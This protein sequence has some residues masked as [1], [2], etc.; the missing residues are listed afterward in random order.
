[1]FEESVQNF[2]ALKIAIERD[3]PSQNAEQALEILNRAFVQ[4]I[5]EWY[6][7]APNEQGEQSVLFL[8]AQA[9]FHFLGNLYIGSIY[10][11]DEDLN[12]SHDATTVAQADTVEVA[13]NDGNNMTEPMEEQPQE[14]PSV[15]EQ[16]PELVSAEQRQQELALAEQQQ[17][18]NALVE[19]RQNELLHQQQQQQRE[20]T[21]E[22][23]SASTACDQP[24][25]IDEKKDA[26]EK[27]PDISTLSF[28]DHIRILHPIF[29]LRPIGQLSESKIMEIILSIQEVNHRARELQVSITNQYRALL[30]FMHG[31]LDITSQQL[32][33]WQ[34]M[35]REPNWDDFIHFLVRRAHTIDP[36]E[37]PRR[38]SA[39]QQPPENNPPQRATIRPSRNS[40]PAP[41]T[42]RSPSVEKCVKCN[43]QQHALI[44]CPA[45]LALSLDER[46][47]FVGESNLC[48][49][50]FSRHHKTK[51]CFRGKCPKCGFKHNSLLG[52]P[53]GA[54]GG[55]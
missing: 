36:A 15:L 55:Y 26:N 47:W 7:L 27:L 8:E 33:M 45:F 20:Q 53:T 3:G 31:L 17:Q 2:N 40:S 5:E 42:S 24:M 14:Q 51:K 18:E 23:T 39:V 6:L 48:D 41:G 9:N 10:N 37:L 38:S 32:W 12:D 43:N 29:S 16:M 4:L 34:L 44:R 46:N 19:Q 22:V 54:T 35:D 30:T 1:M 28:S 52:C 25:Q 13:P 49:N 11:G 50:C 21:G